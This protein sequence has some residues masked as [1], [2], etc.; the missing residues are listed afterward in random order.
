MWIFNFKKKKDNSNMK[1]NLKKCAVDSDL[2]KYA[3]EILSKAVY[4]YDQRDR[5]GK[6][7]VDGGYWFS[8]DV[9]LVKSYCTHRVKGDKFYKAKIYLKNPL[10]VECNHGRHTY[11]VEENLIFSSEVAMKCEETTDDIAKMARDQGYDGVIFKDI[12]ENG[13]FD[14][15]STCSICVF[16][17]KAIVDL[18]NIMD[19]I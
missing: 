4:R 12:K 15:P 7:E 19:K 1:V 18:E 9:Q 2:K 8:S 5:I 14:L 17:S 6:N 13:R 10:V 3:D 16:D 11:L